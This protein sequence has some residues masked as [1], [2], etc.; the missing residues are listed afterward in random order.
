[1]LQ[2]EQVTIMRLKAEGRWFKDE[3]GRTVILRGVNLSGS[4]KVPVRPPGATHLPDSLDERKDISFVGRPFPLEEADEHFSRL[5]RWGLDFLR[6][7]VTWE[8]LEHEGPGI[9]DEACIDYIAAVLEKAAEHDI[10]LLID[11]HQD[12]WSRFSGGDGA[13]A[14]TFDVAG[15]DIDAFHQ[16]GAAALHQKQPDD[17]PNLL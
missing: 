17:F 1:M 2:T 14:W 6:F 13:P 16:T 4:S 10:N 3:A 9:Y 7:V 15:L 12:V 5:K 11:P 8:A